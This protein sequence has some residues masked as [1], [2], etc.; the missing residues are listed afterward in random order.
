MREQT[1]HRMR[2]LRTHFEKVESGE[3]TVEMRLMDEKRRRIVAGDMILFCC[4]EEPS[5]QI[6]AEVIG[7]HTFENF[8][9]LAECFGTRAVGFFGK[10][11]SFVGAYMQGIYGA[12]AIRLYGA[13]ALE[14]RL[15][16][17]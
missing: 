3:K 4:E 11:A 5:R 1:I 13:A 15:R 17:E 8:E 12:E 2:L 10:D 7:V 16:R 14:I 6:A 9:A